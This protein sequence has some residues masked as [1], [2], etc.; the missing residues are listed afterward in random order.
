MM[1]PREAAKELSTRPRTIPVD[2]STRSSNEA[3][4]RVVAC[5]GSMEASAHTSSDV[6]IIA[7]GVATRM[8]DEPEENKAITS[9]FGDLSVFNGHRPEAPYLKTRGGNRRAKISPGLPEWAHS[10]HGGLDQLYSQRSNLSTSY[11][12]A[13]P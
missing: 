13:L 11:A 8:P 5:A 2:F 7:E 4:P 12:R 1:D 6:R 9:H 10:A 3:L